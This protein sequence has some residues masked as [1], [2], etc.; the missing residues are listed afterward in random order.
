LS[1]LGAALSGTPQP[2]PAPL[3]PDLPPG[4][5]RLVYAD[6]SNANPHSVMIVP[7]GGGPAI[8]AAFDP[9][10]QDWV[11][12]SDNAAWSADQ[13][14]VLFTIKVDSTATVEII[15][16]EGDG[17]ASR[18]LATLSD[19]HN[20]LPLTTVWS[21]DG[22][23]AALVL[24]QWGNPPSS[25]T[26]RLVVVDVAGASVTTLVEDANLSEN[27]LAWSPDSATI[28]FS[29]EK[30]DSDPGSLQTIRWDGTDR[31]TLVKDSYVSGLFWPSDGA[32]LFDGRCDGSDYTALCQ[33]DPASGEY[34]PLYQTPDRQ[35][36]L[37][38]LSMSPDEQWLFAQ[39]Y[40]RG[41]LL[42]I[43]RRTGAVETISANR[44]AFFSLVSTWSPDSRYLAVLGQDSQT[45][46]YEVGSGQPLRPLISEQVL[47]WLP[48]Q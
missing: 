41:T 27:H 26:M 29:T 4:S 48:E 39:E 31:K 43:N 2:T 19:N 37:S 40:R 25:D 13:R 33:L 35:D 15:L 9:Q 3:T 1:G 21:P 30:N 32:I 14:A 18:R 38:F 45:Y 8:P 47:A 24:K 22:G 17:S 23:K 34:Q 28:A 42:L 36:N 10:Y 6:Y 11:G 12:L 5:G 44:N 20:V 7:A 46:V 16:A